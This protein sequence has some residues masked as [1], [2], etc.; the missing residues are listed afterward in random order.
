MLLFMDGFDHYGADASR[1]LEGVY[2]EINGV[3]IINTSRTGPR[4]MRVHAGTNNSGARRVLLTEDSTVG[5]AYAFNLNR[6]PTDGRSLALV[7]FLDQENGRACTITVLPTGAIQYKTGGWEGTVELTSVPCILPG[8]YQ[9]FECE[10][11][12][13]GVEVRINGVTRLSG[14]SVTQSAG[15]I[16]Q[17]VI[18]GAY[19]FPKTGAV[20]L[21]F[22]VDDLAVR[23]GTGTRN[24]DFIGDQK[25]Y[26]RFPDT[27]GPEE[28]W[29]VSEGVNSYAMLDNVPPLDS[30]EYL[31][32][33]EPGLRTSVGI[34]AFPAE[35]VAISGVYTATRIFKTD[36]GNAKVA[37][38]VQSGGEEELNPEHP[39]STAPVWY[40]DVFE[41]DPATNAP[42]L[43]T[44]ANAANVVIERVE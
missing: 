27:D 44:G 29:T 8:S 10:V 25:V 11:T 6:L 22:D 16:R 1:M 24:N 17:V 26:T 12:G 28:E 38:G 39:I 31:S 5:V 30:T 20:N 42:W 19:G 18:A 40:G 43:V 32:A 14:T 15:P 2:S 13:G 9:H 35:I 4:A 41:D 21:F 34:A 33:A 7:Q 3:S 23:D 36:A 37:V